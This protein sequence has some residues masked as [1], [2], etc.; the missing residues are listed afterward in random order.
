MAAKTKKLKSLDFTLDGIRGRPRDYNTGSL[1]YEYVTTPQQLEKMKQA[2]W[3]I[4]RIGLDIETTGYAPDENGDMPQ[5][6]TE[7]DGCVRLIQIAI[8]EPVPRQ[9]VIDCFR[10]NPTPVLERIYGMPNKPFWSQKQETVIHY[11][12]FEQPWLA[13][14]YG[15]KLGK[16][17]DTCSAARKINSC[18][19]PEEKMPNVKLNTVALEYLGIDLDK[20][21]QSSDWEE[22]DLTDEQIHYAALDAAI[23]LDLLPI[24]KEEVVRLGVEEDINGG[25]RKLLGAAHYLG[26]K[27]EPSEAILYRVKRAI[28][29]SDSFEESKKVVDCLP[30][31]ALHHTDKERAFQVALKKQT[32]QLAEGKFTSYDYHLLEEALEDNP[33]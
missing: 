17:F 13:Y 22:T 30:S 23:L 11:A 32:E 19:A 8:D 9:W 12:W 4:S 26:K 31:L 25:M 33:F 28:A 24:L 2:F 18:R 21:Q 5:G 3:N 10:V 15:A 14:H 29:Y 27:Q 6:N 7:A 1:N 16:V 20:T